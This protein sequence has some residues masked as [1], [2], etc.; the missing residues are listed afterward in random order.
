MQPLRM[1]RA[2]ARLDRIVTYVTKNVGL[3]T[4]GVRENSHIGKWR[5]PEQM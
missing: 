1:M 3:F 5:M 4:T 2:E